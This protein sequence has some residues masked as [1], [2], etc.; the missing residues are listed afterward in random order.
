MVAIQSRKLVDQCP[1]GHR[2]QGNARLRGQIVQCP[3]CHAGFPF[4]AA[5]DAGPVRVFS[6][7]SD[8]ESPLDDDLSNASRSTEL[9]AKAKE[10][11]AQ[12]VAAI[13]ESLLSE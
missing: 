13:R 12:T 1:N 4:A 6:N 10:S 11:I 8:L 9:K 2:V 3:R 7:L 5:T